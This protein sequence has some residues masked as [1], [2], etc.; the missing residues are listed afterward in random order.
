MS[1]L[2]ILTLLST[3]TIFTLSYS[4]ASLATS[5][6]PLGVGGFALGN[7]IDNYPDLM[8]T[9]YLQETVVTDW[10]GFRKGVLSYGTCKYNRQIL[11]IQ[12]KYVDSSQ[13]F[14][15]TLLQKFKA[16]F[17]PPDEWKGDS[18]GILRNWKWYFTDSQDRSVSL[19]LQHNLRNPNETTGNMVK[20]SF[21]QLLEEERLCFNR[22]CE[23]M[24]ND[25][26]RERIEEIKKPDWKFMIPD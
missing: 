25:H 15:E 9:N 20:I 8:E 19:V 4:G 21:P 7:N 2:Y 3:L 13:D 6:V 14:Y 16:K 18:F 12:M 26:D 17:G 24:R 10:R 1:K 11:K 5:E 22:K 23:E